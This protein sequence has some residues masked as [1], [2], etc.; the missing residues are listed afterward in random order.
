MQVIL[1]T[2]ASDDRVLNKSLYLLGES[3]CVPKD[4][5]SIHQPSIIIKSLS[6]DTLSKINY[7]R[8]P[9]WNRY[10][11]VNEIVT[12]TGGRVML[13]CRVDVLMSYK[14]AILNTTS[15]IARQ[16]NIYN[17][18]ITDNR[19]Q[20]R[21]GRIQTVKKLADISENR[22]FYITSIGG[23]QIND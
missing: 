14:T 21:K 1:Y 4:N 18:F 12:L 2:N 9:N 5:C 8:I 3:E 15:L 7:I 19:L 6:D 16:E 17:D 22:Y 20:F 13:N 23:G 10:Y 11:Y